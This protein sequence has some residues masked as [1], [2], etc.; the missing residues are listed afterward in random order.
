MLG[1][2]LR[3]LL[4]LLA[5]SAAS[6]FVLDRSEAVRRRGLHRGAMNIR[7][8]TLFRHKTLRLRRAVVA[9]QRLHRSIAR[10]LLHPH[11]IG[12]GLLGGFGRAASRAV[13]GP[14]SIP[15][16]FRLTLVV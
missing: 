12:R 9:H 6:A 14:R 8:P 15:F 1:A 5:F 13:A 11:Q 16:G 2:S 4:A 10:E 7:P 3:F